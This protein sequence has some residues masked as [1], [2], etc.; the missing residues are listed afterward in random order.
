[1][2][3]RNSTG[4][5]TPQLHAPP[6][7]FECIA[8]V[9]HRP[10]VDCGGGYG[11]RYEGYTGVWKVPM[12]SIIDVTVTGAAQKGDNDVTYERQIRSNRNGRLNY[13]V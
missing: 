13:A 4:L 9:Q 1:M 12:S 2:C 10:N 3:V 7:Q 6:P 5:D 8:V 11:A